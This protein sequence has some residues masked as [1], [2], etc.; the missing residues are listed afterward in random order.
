VISN[1]LEELSARVE[2]GRMV[3][4]PIQADDSYRRFVAQ[5]SEDLFYRSG[6]WA[7]PRSRDHDPHD[8]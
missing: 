3:D 5:V 8:W 1:L 6:G 2:P 7:G 4:G